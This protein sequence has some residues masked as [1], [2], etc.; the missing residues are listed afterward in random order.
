MAE[1]ISTFTLSVTFTQTYVD[2]Y[3]SPACTGAYCRLKMSNCSDNSTFSQHQILHSLCTGKC[4]SYRRKDIQF[5]SRKWNNG[6][7]FVYP[8]NVHYNVMNLCSVWLLLWTDR[9]QEEVGTG[10]WILS[11]ALQ[12]AEGCFQHSLQ[13][14]SGNK[15]PYG[16]CNRTVT[17]L[18]TKFVCAFLFSDAD[19]YDVAP[20][21]GT[22]SFH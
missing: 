19:L 21:I 11:T 17:I 5:V 20:Y 1:T 8:I 15:P 9:W 10:R 14:T 4:M 6:S 3:R 2:G 16:A 12:N 18:D 22:A 7:G 13:A